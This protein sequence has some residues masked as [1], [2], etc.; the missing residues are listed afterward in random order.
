VLNI[1]TFVPPISPPGYIYH[2]MDDTRE[3]L[4]TIDTWILEQLNIHVYS[5]CIPQRQEPL[6]CYM[7]SHVGYAL[8]CQDVPAIDGI[9][10]AAVPGA[11][12]R[13]IQRG[14]GVAWVH[15]RDVVT[16]W[17]LPDVRAAYE[18]FF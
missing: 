1:D 10:Q 13:Q 17:R 2:A 14:D 5:P 9:M 8:R 16:T 7:P 15:D 11:A 18:V 6:D 3:Q 12:P 4:P